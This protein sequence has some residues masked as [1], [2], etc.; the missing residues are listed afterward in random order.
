MTS[1]NSQ[2]GEVINFEQV[3]HDSSLEG[4]VEVVEGSQPNRLSALDVTITVIGLTTMI[5]AD[6]WLQSR[7]T[8][9]AQAVIDAK[10]RGASKSEIQ[11]LERNARA[12]VSAAENEIEERDRG[13]APAHRNPHSVEHLRSGI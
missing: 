6:K 5:L 9:T 8:A 13:Q 7:K 11:K 1:Q 4:T 3:P 10:A 12:A 2:V